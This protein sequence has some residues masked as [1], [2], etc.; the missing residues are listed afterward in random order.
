MG[1]RVDAVNLN[2][3]LEEEVT[4]LGSCQE[5]PTV[6]ATQFDFQGFSQVLVLT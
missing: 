3:L 2:T 4:A 5:V 1:T 6:A